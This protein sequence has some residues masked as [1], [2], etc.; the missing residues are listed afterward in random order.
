MGAEQYRLDNLAWAGA[1]VV[2][3]FVSSLGVAFLAR[4]VARLARLSNGTQRKV[5]NGF[6]FAGPWIVG[7]IIFVVGPALVSLYYS[8]T[9]YKLGDPIQWVGL[10]NYQFFLVG[11]ASQSRQFTQAVFNS[12]YY[13]L[14][15]VPLQIGAAL[16]MAMLLNRA[17]P[18]IRVFRTVFYLPVIL[19]GGAATLLAWR[20]MFATNGGFVNIALQK[21]AQSFFVF[22]FLYRLFIFLV[23]G[24]N[25]FWAGLTRGEAVGPLMYVLPAALGFLIFLTLAFDDWSENKRVRA[26]RAAQ[27]IGLIILYALG[28]R[29]LTLTP[30]DVSWTL[31]VAVVCIGMV[32]LNLIAGK[33]WEARLWQYGGLVLFALGAILTLTAANFDLSGDALGYLLALLAGAAPLVVSIALGLSWNART[34]R[35][36]SVMAAV[37]GVIIFIRLIPGQLDGGR[38]DLLVRYLT[39]Q[40]AL[41]EP[42]STS[43]LR[44]LFPN[45]YFSPLW[46]Y[47]AVVAVLLVYA[48]V[49]GRYKDTNKLWRYIAYGA[50]IVFGLFMVSSALDGRNYFQAFA[51][52]AQADGKPVYHFALFR[53]STAQFPGSERLPMWMTNE[54]WSKPS[55]VLITMWSSGAGMLIFLAALK[56]VPKHLYEAAQVDGAT[57]VQQFFKIT[58]PMISPAIFYNLVIGVIAALQTFDT[59]YIIQTTQTLDSL[60]SA[61]YL[62]FSRTFTQLFI[63]EGAALSWILA[64]IILTVTALQ[65]RFSRWVYYEA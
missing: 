57:R 17:L 62:I 12:F 18:L 3:I 36:I 43:Y 24:F 5:F 22:D 63:G 20:Y 55:L 48:F 50:L 10:Q 47:A 34:M 14:I 8:F 35:I 45:Q 52:I 38:L 9:N 42:T 33:K 32:S 53:N 1:T 4:F 7:F 16:G 56:G 64:L 49:G 26:I 41:T 11:G 61:A 6:A 23:E 30:I 40:S 21:L 60:R 46:V 29:W 31:F 39:L 27:I 19:A 28:F 59:I 13:A 2:F 51:D 58:L 37:L 54:L 15:G 25:G 65:F 44:D